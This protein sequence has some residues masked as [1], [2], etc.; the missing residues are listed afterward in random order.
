MITTGLGGNYYEENLAELASPPPR[1]QIGAYPLPVEKIRRLAERVRRLVVIEEG[2]PFVERLLRGLLPGRVEVLGKEGGPVPR[3]GEL[4]PD[5]VRPAMGLPGRKGQE[6]AGLELPAR[7]PQLCAGCPHRDT[8]DALNLARE[9]LPE[10]LVTSDIGC[11]TLGYLP[12]YSAIESCVC[13]GASVGMAK[14]ASEAG[15]RPVTAVIGDSTFLHSGITPL[16]D[17]VAAG[18]D[19][20]LIIL[21]NS[22][23]AMTGCQETLLTSERIRKLVEGIGV[24]PAHIRVINPLRRHTRGERADHPRGDGAPRRVGGHRPARVHP[25]GEG[26]AMKYDVIL[27]GVGGQGVLSVAAI[28]ARGALKA[29]LEVRQSEVHGMAQRGGAV[30]AHLR[31]SDR[32]IAADLVGRGRADLI[33]SMEPLEGLRYLAWLEPGGTLITAGEPV[34]NIPDY[35]ETGEVHDAVRRLPR[36]RLIEAEALARQAGSARA[37]NMVM[38]GAASAG[39]P[40]AAGHLQQAI[41][42][43]FAAKG[44]EVVRVNLEAFRL[45]REAVGKDRPVGAASPEG[46]RR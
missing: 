36:G 7:P 24:E 38:V 3:S 37:T 18:T 31:L 6:P 11:Y 39:L 30:Q 1:L 17:A 33:L 5:N 4:D 10:S 21:D 34:R 16:L 40:V 46:G 29:G 23:T 42:E 22:T 13:M 14:G 43:A 44:A 27:A 15:F 8:Y 2:Y 12:P 20:T 45:G 35:P 26:E 41:E 28:I 32:P 25:G 19:L 9:G